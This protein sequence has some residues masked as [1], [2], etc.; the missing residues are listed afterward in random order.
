M[1]EQ[2][3][4][5][6]NFRRKGVP[7][8]L[9]IFEPVGLRMELIGLARQQGTISQAQLCARIL[10]FCSNKPREIIGSTSGHVAAAAVRTGGG[11]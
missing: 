6:G 3:R 7:V 11:E 4:G 5:R 9:Y 1:R 10:F 8:S 2:T